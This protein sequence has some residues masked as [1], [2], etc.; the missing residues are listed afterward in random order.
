MHNFIDLKLYGGWH[1]LALIA[2]AQPELFYL[3]VGAKGWRGKEAAA[4]VAV[5]RHLDYLYQK[6]RFDFL[7]PL[8]MLRELERGSIEYGLFRASMR[9][10]FLPKD[11]YAEPPA[12]LLKFGL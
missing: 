3:D 4:L 7:Q 6:G 10:R 2:V 12:R 9:H 1:P 11:L 5:L 8:S